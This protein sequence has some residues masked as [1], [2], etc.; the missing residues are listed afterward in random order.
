MSHNKSLNFIMT[1]K[2]VNSLSVARSNADFLAYKF[3]SISLKCCNSLQCLKV[4][5]ACSHIEIMTIFISTSCAFFQMVNLAK[6]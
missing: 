3:S 5:Q 6:Y 2:R 4:G 1:P